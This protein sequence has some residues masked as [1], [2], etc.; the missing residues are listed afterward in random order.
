MIRRN[1]LTT[2]IA[3]TGSISIIANVS[4]GIEPYFAIG[5]EKNVLEGA[6]LKEFNPLFEDKIRKYWIKKDIY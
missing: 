4:S 6:I 5:F 2:T 3:P 1:L